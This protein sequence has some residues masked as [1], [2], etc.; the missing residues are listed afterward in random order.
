[1]QA[2]LQFIRQNRLTIVLA[3][4]A[5]LLAAAISQYLSHA[6][7]ADEADVIPANPITVELITA[8]SFDEQSGFTVLGT[9]SATDR[10]LV[11]TEVGGQIASIRVAA[12]DTVRSGALIATLKNETQLAAVAQAEAALAAAEAGAAQNNVGTVSAETALTQA[13]ANGRTAISNSY[14]TAQRVMLNDIDQFFSN[15][16]DGVIGSRVGSGQQVRSLNDQRVAL[17]DTLRAWEALSEQPLLETAAVESGLETSQTYT[18]AVLQLVNTLIS[19][20]DNE[21]PDR[22]NSLAGLRAQQ[23]QL[24]QSRDQLLNSRSAQQNALIQISNSRNSAAQAA[25]SGTTGQ[26]SA[27][28]AQIDQAAAGLRSARAQLNNTY[29]RSPIAGTVDNLDLTIG[30]FVPGGT[31]VAEI[32]NQTA[33]E[34]DTFVTT[35]E[36]GRIN[37]GDIVTIAQEYAGTVTNIAPTADQA[38]GKI[39]VTIT[40]SNADLTI[41]STAQVTFVAAN[42]TATPTNAP[43]QIPITAV[44]FSGSDTAVMRVSEENTLYS[45]PVTLGS[46]VGNV[47]TVLSGI[48]STTPIVRDVR[49]KQVNDTVT[50][51]ND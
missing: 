22:Q 20:I 33:L 34:I 35:N 17:R 10:A 4:G 37:V 25:I 19:A 32:T 23:S 15:P 3:I 40:T 6:E 43:L 39:P 21:S 36:R 14:S 51:T 46:T 29:L 31:T 24:T 16:Q 13:V 11:T 28:Q 27:A 9:V 26:L 1:M 49:G 18:A 38:N 48:S 2:L 50:V 47:V 44:R 8:N 42:A 12:G 5:L 30:Q 7:T 45:E 41:G